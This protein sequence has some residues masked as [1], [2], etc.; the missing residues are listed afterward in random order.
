MKLAPML[1]PPGHEGQRVVRPGG[2][3]RGMIWAG[4]VEA[5]PDEAAHGERVGRA[6]G[7]PALGV[8]PFEVGRAA[9]TGSIGPAAIRDAPSPRH[10]TVDTAPPR[11]GRSR[12]RRG[13]RSAA[14][15]RDGPAK[16][17]VRSSESRSGLAGSCVCPSPWAAV[18][19]PTRFRPEISHRLS[20]RT[21]KCFGT[22]RTGV[23]LI[24]RSDRL[25]LSLLAPRQLDGR[26]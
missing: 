1:A 10:R 8:E 22:G 7:N 13:W 4:L 5:E 19:G 11:T 14:R 23:V 12:R 21:V 9:A 20:P 2:R 3:D 18:Y 15:R 16:R 24:V 25:V 26:S 17:G 6:P